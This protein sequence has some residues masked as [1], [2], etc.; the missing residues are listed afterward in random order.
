MSRD[1][2]KLLPV[3][4]DSS[5]IERRKAVPA[6]EPER[7]AFAKT[8]KAAVVSS[9]LTFIVDAIGATN[10]IDSLNFSASK[11]LV[12]NDLAITSVSLVDSLVSNPKPLSVEAIISAASAISIPEETA[13][14]S[15]PEVA[16]NIPVVVKP[17][18]ASSV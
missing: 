17:I 7:P 16:F 12:T 10:F 6:I 8:P 4:A 3:L 15:A 13:K 1:S 11:A 14:S 2:L 5:C 18:L 9:K